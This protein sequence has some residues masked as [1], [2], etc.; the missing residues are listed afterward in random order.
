MSCRSLHSVQKYSNIIKKKKTGETHLCNSPMHILKGFFW[1]VCIFVFSVYLNFDS[2][3][4]FFFEQFA[5]INEERRVRIKTSGY[6]LWFCGKPEGNFKD[7]SQFGMYKEMVPFTICYALKL[8]FL[9]AFPPLNWI[10]Y[11]WMLPKELVKS[12]KNIGCWKI[13]LSTVLFSLNS[14]QFDNDLIL[15]FHTLNF[16]NMQIM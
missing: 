10:I 6:N 14:F 3:S 2:Y 8:V 1:F 15:K 4:K 7:F 12:K 9:R 13:D 11:K 5:W 16:R